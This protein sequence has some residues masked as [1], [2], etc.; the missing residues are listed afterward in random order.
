MPDF[1]YHQNMRNFGGGTA[2]RNTAYQGALAATSAAIPA[3]GRISIAGFTEITNYETASYAFGQALPVG[4]P[5]VPGG[6]NAA[7]INLSRALGINFIAN[8]ACGETAGKRKEYVALAAHATLD[9]HAVG[10]IFMKV[11]SKGVQLI[12][13]IIDPTHAEFVDWCQTIPKEATRD[14]R[15]L[16][17]LVARITPPTA[18]ARYIA[19]GFLHN[20][21]T[22]G[23]AGNHE[24]RSLIA[25]QIP[26]MMKIL[27]SEIP[28]GAGM[29][30]IGGDF[31]LAPVIRGNTNRRLTCY[32]YDGIINPATV[33]PAMVANLSQGQT[34][35]TTWSGNTYDYWYS[36]IAPNAAA[37]PFI[38]PQSV[39]HHN[40]MTGP[41]NAAIAV[42]PMSD[43]CGT[44][45]RI[46]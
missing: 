27:Q 26:S 33:L 25:E 14:Y 7:P 36:T 6:T 10:R 22:V 45:L 3:G 42:S 35:G 19:A 40:T 11:S 8:V 21:Y 37:P 20:M 13:D 31:N 39:A 44:S 28:N 5:L 24:Q 18:P 34:G 23:V 2:V 12:N 17:Y 15:A 9:V 46:T 16:V 1:L 30:Y 41:A 29:A 38:I 4:H 43:H 32:P